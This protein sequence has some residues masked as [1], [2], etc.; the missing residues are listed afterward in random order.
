MVPGQAGDNAWHWAVHAQRPMACKKGPCH[1]QSCKPETTEET[2]SLIARPEP[3]KWQQL[4]RGKPNILR[5]PFLEVNRGK[6][7]GGKACLTES[8]LFIRL[9]YFT[10][11]TLQKNFSWPFVQYQNF[12][13]WK[14]N[15]SLY[16][17]QKKSSWSTTYGHWCQ[18]CQTHFH[19]GPH[20]S[21]GCL[22]RT[23]CNFR[24]V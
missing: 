17:I 19:R 9:C 5:T 6:H 20:Q 10:S 4:P 24:T 11:T 23:E 7:W 12:Y 13:S 14:Y 1:H 21:C 3:E 18:G 2:K 8:G 15:Q 22:Q 16:S